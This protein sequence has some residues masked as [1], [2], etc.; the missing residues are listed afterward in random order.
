MSVL[1]PVAAAPTAEPQPLPRPERL[2]IV[3]DDGFSQQLIE[4]YLRRAGFH[5]LTSAGDGRVALDLAKAERFD[6]V[7]LDLNLPR[8]SGVEVLRR[9]KRDG[10]LIDTP[11][12]V[13]SSMTNMDEI[14]QCLD[15]GAEGYLPK[16]FN[17][18]LLDE[19][20]SACLEMRRLKRLAVDQ[21]DQRQTDTR[22]VKALHGLLHADPATLDPQLSG[23]TASIFIHPAAHVGGDISLLHRHADGTVWAA[24][25]TVGASGS[26]AALTAAYALLHLRTLIERGDAG[27]AAALTALNQRLS[28]GAEG[29][30]CPPVALSLLALTPRRGPFASPVPVP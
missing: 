10:L 13:I 22:A 26:A 11:V 24:L 3:E 25:G 19:R 29:W 6:L 17:V 27:P 7:L 21:I 14:V 16:P 18:R 12:I 1:S 2:L 23:A 9:L 28:Q 20:V 5:D 15:L 8:V 30:D 4:L